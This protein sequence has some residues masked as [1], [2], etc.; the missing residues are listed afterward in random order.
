MS[1]S[2]ENDRK[3]H[4]YETVVRQIWFSSTFS[5]SQISGKK[6]SETEVHFEEIKK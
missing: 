5:D 3:M 4:E 6:E 2:N 1:Q